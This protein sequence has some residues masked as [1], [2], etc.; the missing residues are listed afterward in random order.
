MGWKMVWVMKM[1]GMVWGE[2][3]LSSERPLRILR[4]GLV[5]IIITFYI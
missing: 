1:N 4:V 2:L 5:C 3:N